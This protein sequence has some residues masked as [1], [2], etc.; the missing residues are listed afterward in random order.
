MITAGRAATARHIAE[1]HAA[2]LPAG[3]VQAIGEDAVLGQLDSMDMNDAK[4]RATPEREYGMGR[5]K[6]GRSEGLLFC[7]GRIQDAV[8]DSYRNRIAGNVVFL[9]LD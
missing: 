8:R 3:D 4:H 9:D 2:K 6:C 1:S 5:R 7:I